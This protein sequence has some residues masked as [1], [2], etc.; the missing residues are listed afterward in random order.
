MLTI[1]PL[2][3]IYVLDHFKVSDS[4]HNHRCFDYLSHIKLLKQMLKIGVSLKRSQVQL[5]QR[6]VDND[7]FC[8]SSILWRN[9]FLIQ[10]QKWSRDVRCMNLTLISHIKY[11]CNTCTI[12]Q[13]CEN[14][15]SDAKGT[16]RE[17]GLLL[18]YYYST[19]YLLHLYQCYLQHE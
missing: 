14:L 5:F 3:K 16:S 19:Y 13:S 1:T 6:L 12:L 4:Y 11:V 10:M 7:V 8:S 2:D 17:W 9:A 15:L 18:L